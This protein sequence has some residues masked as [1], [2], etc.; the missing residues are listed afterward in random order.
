MAL[1]AHAVSPHAD[2]SPLV[3]KLIYAE[4][5]Y[6]TTQ[7]TCTPKGAAA[8]TAH[9]WQQIYQQPMLLLQPQRSP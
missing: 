2:S 9:A 8:F 4:L 3:L 1:L 7:T 6:E 5:P